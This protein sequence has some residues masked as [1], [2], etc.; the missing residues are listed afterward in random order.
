MALACQRDTQLQY[1]IKLA[2]KLG[3]QTASFTHNTKRFHG[4]RRAHVRATIMLLM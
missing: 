4:K 3:K 2:V 1:E